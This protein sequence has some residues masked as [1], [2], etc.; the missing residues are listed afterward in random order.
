MTHIPTVSTIAQAT[1]QQ[2][3]K[4][5]AMEGSRGKHLNLSSAHLA[6]PKDSILVGSVE[7]CPIL[8]GMSAQAPRSWAE[9]VAQTVHYHPTSVGNRTTVNCSSDS[10]E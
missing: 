9:R 8:G 5:S 3:F 1:L 6:L 4:G 10:R 2:G 7:G